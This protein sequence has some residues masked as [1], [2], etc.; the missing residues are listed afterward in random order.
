M[1]KDKA[2]R[3]APMRKIS[4]EYAD[5]VEGEPAAAALRIA[6]FVSSFP[7]TSET[8]IARQV[9]GLL[10]RGHEVRIFAHEPASEGPEHETTERHQLRQ[11]V[12][13]V[14][15]FDG[16]PIRPS[17]SGRQTVAALRCFRPRHAHV[18]GGWISLA[19]TVSVLAREDPFDIVHCHYGNV[20]LHYAPAACVWNAPLVVSFYGYDCSSYPRERGVRVYDPLFAAADA[21]ISLSDH[22]DAR[23]RSLGCPP[24]LLRRVPLSIDPMAHPT[25]SSD[26]RPGEP[27]RLL[28]V[29]R[30]TEKKGIEDALRGL[31][32]LGD[33]PPRIRYD[34]IGDGPLRPALESLAATLGVS[35]RVR[36]LGALGERGVQDALCAADIF[37]LPS[38]TAANG[39]EEGTPTVLLEAGWARLP[40]LA[41]RHAGIP[42]VV[43]DGESGILIPERDPSALAAAIRDLVCAPERWTAMGDAGH[44]LVEAAHTIPLVAERLEATYRDCIRDRGN[45]RVARGPATRVAR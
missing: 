18:A 22:M 5:G 28:T 36:F 33:E 4:K 25:V 40:V 29:A 14:P 12:T 20:G 45:G 8:F 39:D 26:R 31:A 21:I 32:L 43:R 24:A 19:R 41:T 3:R 15:R 11:L 23:L 37:V 1:L 7:E 35:E 17:I 27:V 2:Q 10:D 16:A 34:V 30:L 42:E 13:V 44:R 6:F 9:V 38:V